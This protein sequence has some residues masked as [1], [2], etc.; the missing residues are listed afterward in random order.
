MSSRTSGVRPRPFFIFGCPRSGTS[1]LTRM[2]DA[3][4][5]LAIPYESHFY[6]WAYPL[7]QRYCDLRNPSTRAGVVREMLRTDPMTMWSPPLSAEETLAAI[8]RPDL[9][10]LFEGLMQAWTRRQGKSRWGEKTPPH[11]LLWR[12]IHAGFPDLQVI[13]LVRDG[14]DVALSHKAAPFGPKHV[15]QA[16]RRWVTYLSAAEEAQA[17]LGEGAFLTVRY[18]DLLAEPEPELRRIC[19]FLGEEFAPEMLTFYTG[20]FAYPTDG[21]N[22]ANLRKPVLSD[23]AG[24]WRTRMSARELRIFEAIAGPELERYG[25]PRALEHPRISSL[26]TLSCRYL[27]HP[28]RRVLAMLK[29]RQGHRYAFQR[30]RF[31]LLVRTGLLT[32]G[33]KDV[34]GERKA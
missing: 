22:I 33:R 12:T 5:N 34:S 6:N 16:A 31:N 32:A 26:E 29:N 24:K 25:Y 30:L 18:E 21:R 1:L 8:P 27:E 3:H 9:H 15:Y 4:P 28:P 11:T 10:G 7:V 20:E 17:T 23:N 19:T 14:R 2:L 13:H